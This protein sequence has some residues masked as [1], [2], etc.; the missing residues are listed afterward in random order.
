MTLV[1]SSSSEPMSSQAAY[2]VTVNSLARVLRWQ[3]PDRTHKIDKLHRNGADITENT[4]SSSRVVTLFSDSPGTVAGLQIRCLPIA[5][6]EPPTLRDN[7]H[8]SVSRKRLD[9]FVSM[10]TQQYVTS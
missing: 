4:P 5:M 2:H 9:D 3:L 6:W 10:V 8:V 7:R 1:R